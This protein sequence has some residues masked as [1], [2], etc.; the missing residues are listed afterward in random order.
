MLTY[1]EVG[2]RFRHEIARMAVED[3]IPVHRRGRLHA[4][5]LAA[6]RAASSHDDARMAYHAEGAADRA[7]VLDYAPRAARAAAELASHREAVA[8]YER[9]LRFATGS[10]AASLA[11]LYDGLASE[12]GLVDRWQTS[13]DA[14]QAALALWR[15][16][17]DPVR[18]GDTLRLLTRALW[19]LCRGAEAVAAA[20]QALSVLEPLP[21]TRELAWAYANLAGQR[22]LVGVRRRDRAGPQ[23]ADIG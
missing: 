16:A 15:Q 9:A 23:G 3:A 22:M 10:E 1:D 7:A 21:P 14:R 11:A 17:D 5:V 13:A 6:L 18:E 2:L 19:R 20:E 4:A 8:Q 12:A